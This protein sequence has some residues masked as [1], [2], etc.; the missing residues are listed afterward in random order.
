M[1]GGGAFDFPG[2]SPNGYLNSDTPE[3]KRIIGQSGVAIPSGGQ[4][5]AASA[6]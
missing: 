6:T 2:G 3:N 5:L 1:L 4:A